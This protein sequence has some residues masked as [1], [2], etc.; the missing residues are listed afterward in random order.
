LLAA[1]AGLGRF[2]SEAAADAA[3]IVE[4]DKGEPAPELQSGYAAVARAGENVDD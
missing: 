4:V 1:T 3:V 2:P